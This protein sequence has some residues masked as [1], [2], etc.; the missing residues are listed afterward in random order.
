[1]RV[2]VGLL[3]IVTLLGVALCQDNDQENYRGSQ[4][5]RSRYGSRYGYGGPSYRRGGGHQRGSRYRQ[6]GHYHDGYRRKYI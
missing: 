5:S 6:G 3:F 1:M 2:F 4:Q